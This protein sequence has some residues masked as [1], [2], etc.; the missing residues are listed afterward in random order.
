MLSLTGCAPFVTAD[1]LRE[2]ADPCAWTAAH[3]GDKPL[4]GVQS[5]CEASWI[6]NGAERAGQFGGVLA[7]VGDLDGDGLADL[8]VGS[9][10]ARDARGIVQV[11][12]SKALGAQQ[13]LHAE[14]AS[15]TLVGESEGDGAG[16]ALTALD[17]QDGEPGRELVVA[18][19]HSDLGGQ[20]GGAV[21]LTRT[22]DLSRGPELS[23][24]DVPT[25]FLGNSRFEAGTSL[26]VADSND[27]DSFQ[28]LVIGAPHA[29]MLSSQGGAYFVVHSSVVKVNE[30]V[31]L[32]D[33]AANVSYITADS[34]FGESLA[35]FDGDPD[36]PGAQGVLVGAP[37]H[38]SWDQYLWD[39]ANWGRGWLFADGALPL[40][41]TAAS[42]L[43]PYSSFAV[44]LRAETVFSYT[45]EEIRWRDDQERMGSRVAVVPDMD[46]GGAD[47]P[48]LVGYV[49][50]PGDLAAFVV[51]GEDMEDQVGSIFLLEDRAAVRLFGGMEGSDFVPT[52][53]GVHDL[54]GDGLG[55][56]LIGDPTADS[57]EALDVGRVY[58]FTSEQLFSP[59]D[60]APRSL[61]LTDAA[62]TLDGPAP[63]ARFG[64]S[65][66]EVGDVDGD[67]RPEVAI[68]APGSADG[69]QLFVGRVFVYHGR[70]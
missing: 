56:L 69:G 45:E 27:G 48:V 29:S 68:G 41:H 49:N 64:E 13:V 37:L 14:H 30:A 21:Y 7:S 43:E 59:D 53:A 12:S 65:I 2:Q 62:Y 16:S 6:V 35:V 54:D 44:N 11:F 70:R 46:G 4:L 18:A 3:V 61:S 26:A 50:G 38:P 57:D 32:R 33:F 23:L 24:A 63:G 51:R 25:R 58:V 40:P 55:E 47:E 19:P 34:S 31:V 22:A 20:D 66:R 1:D 60:T 42:V 10:D 9:P 17:S 5:A 52:V 28:E 15:L 67:G 39:D 8:V 36:K